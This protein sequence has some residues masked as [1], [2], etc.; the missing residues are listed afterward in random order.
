[1]KDLFPLILLKTL[2]AMIKILSLHHLTILISTLDVLF[3]EESPHFLG[4]LLQ[5]LTKER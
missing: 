3:F 5:L 1:M 4:L 2:C